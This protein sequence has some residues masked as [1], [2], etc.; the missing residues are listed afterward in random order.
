MMHGSM[1]IK[2]KVDC[3]SFSVHSLSTYPKAS[4]SISVKLWLYEQKRISKLLRC[5]NVAGPIRVRRDIA[6]M[7]SS[8]SNSR[9]RNESLSSSN[10]GLSFRVSF[11]SE[12]PAE[13]VACIGE[14][15]TAYNTFVKKT[16][17]E[18]II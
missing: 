7:F 15:R 6:L 8:R 13:Q 17:R 11:C 16:G 18:I 5:V 2:Q 4:S 14:M 10:I 12:S 1:N 9:P 3:T